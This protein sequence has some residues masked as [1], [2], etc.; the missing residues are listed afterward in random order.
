MGTHNLCFIAEIKIMY[1]LQTPFF[2]IKVGF[3]RIKITQTC[4]RDV[5]AHV[6]SLIRIFT[7]ACWIAQNAKFLDAEN[8][9]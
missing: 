4:F 8:S 1:T 7:D 3:E 2:Y 5:C 6:C 9:D